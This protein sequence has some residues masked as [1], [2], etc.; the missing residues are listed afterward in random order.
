MPI[1][2][3]NEIQAT[4][5]LRF[6]ARRSR[7]GSKNLVI[8]NPCQIPWD[9]SDDDVMKERGKTAEV[10]LCVAVNRKLRH[11]NEDPKLFRKKKKENYL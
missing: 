11:E 9:F 3:S 5:F 10:V 1:E 4:S 6:A 7:E 2:G 8:T